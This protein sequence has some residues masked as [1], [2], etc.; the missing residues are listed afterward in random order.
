MDTLLDMILLQAD[1]MDLKANET[2]PAV[3]TVVEAHLDQK[4]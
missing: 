3:A 2:R 1:L 4:L